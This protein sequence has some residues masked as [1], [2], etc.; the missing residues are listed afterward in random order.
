MYLA[1][2]VC[3]KISLDIFAVQNCL[4]ITPIE[5]LFCPITAWLTYPLLKIRN[6]LLKWLFNDWDTKIITFIQKKRIMLRNWRI[7]FYNQLEL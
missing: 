3:L 1:D 2:A 6:Y 7:M 4:N 5:H